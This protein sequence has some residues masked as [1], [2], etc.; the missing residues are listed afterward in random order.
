MSHPSGGSW[1][2][3]ERGADETRGLRFSP[4]VIAARIPARHSLQPIRRFVIDVLVR[5]GTE[6]ET[7]HAPEDRPSI[8]PGWLIR[9]GLL[10]SRFSVRSERRLTEQLDFLGCRP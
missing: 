4:V 9:A 1:R 6:F 7:L 10:Q 8:P 5:P 3:W 2:G